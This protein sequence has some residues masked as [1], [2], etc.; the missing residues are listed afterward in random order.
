M[1]KCFINKLK[2]DD[3]KRLA[4]WHNLKNMKVIAFDIDGT[5]L[6]RTID[7]I[8]GRKADASSNGRSLYFRPNL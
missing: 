4:I 5:L 7:K 6:H 3:Y 1:L 2:A 8:K